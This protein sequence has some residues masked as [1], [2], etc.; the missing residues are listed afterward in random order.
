MNNGVVIRPLEEKKEEKIG[1]ILVPNS[2]KQ[3]EKNKH[4]VVVAV[5]AG[6][7]ED[8]IQVK[9]GDR[10]SYTKAVYPISEGCEVVSQKDILYIE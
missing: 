10:V 3:S 9:V 1:L 8:P 5:G 2:V 7:K 6:T 4:G